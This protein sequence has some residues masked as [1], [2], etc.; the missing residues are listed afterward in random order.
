M[1]TTQQTE[2]KTYKDALR[3]IV[4]KNQMQDL[5]SPDWLV[6]ND[7]ITPAVLA[8]AFGAGFFVAYPGFNLVRRDLKTME[9][10]MVKKAMKDR[11][12]LGFKTN[13]DLMAFRILTKDIKMIPEIV[14]EVKTR[15]EAKGN[16]VLVRGSIQDEHG[17]FTDIIQYMYVYHADFGY[18][19]EYQIGHPFAALKFKHDSAVRDGKPGLDF[20]KAKVKVYKLIK[21]WVLN[22]A[23][24]T[25]SEV[26]DIWKEG[27]GEEMS[28]EWAACF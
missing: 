26:Q 1:Q 7:L 16:T 2:I 14:D 22:Q 23:N 9:R 3:A 6:L 19:A 5:T 11:P 13:C 25:P 17:M 27:F 21:E 15:N 10:I 12:D 24:N 28:E 18:L 4:Q 20:S 8:D